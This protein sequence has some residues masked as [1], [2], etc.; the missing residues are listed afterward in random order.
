VITNSRL[1]SKFL[2]GY[3]SQLKNDGL[4]AQ[5]QRI[6][7]LN[8]LGEFWNLRVS[9]PPLKE[10]A[11]H[12]LDGLV[13]EN[14]YQNYLNNVN[15]VIQAQNLEI[16][17]ALRKFFV[18]DLKPRHLLFLFFVGLLR[19][20]QVHLLITHPYFFVDA[21]SLLYKCRANQKISENLRSFVTQDLSDAL[22]LHHRH[23]VGNM[24]IQ[25][26]Q[27]SPREIP[28]TKYVQILLELS[29]SY[30]SLPKYL[31]TDA[32]EFDL[33][34]EPPKNQNDSWQN[35]P[36]FSGGSMF[37]H[38]A[39]LSALTQNLFPDFIVKRGGDPLETLANMA[40]C[41]YLIISNSSFSYVAGLLGNH[42]RLWIPKN[43]WHT[44]LSHWIQYE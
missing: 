41:K 13:D 35:L 26:G 8:A 10:I 17:G 7:A 19:T 40:S 25:P 39:S 15:F 27:N 18:K 22:V 31:Y 28:V 5:L 4:G 36:N 43:F 32:P 38:G 2:L 12:P 23:G 33:L 42:S 21:D 24:A 34:F 20:G 30:P 1:S 37:I 29:Q 14:S 16:S 9:H 6:L 44:P 3:S 11:V